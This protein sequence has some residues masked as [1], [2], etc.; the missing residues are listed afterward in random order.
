M[1]YDIF[2]FDP[3]AAPKDQ[4]SFSSWYATQTDWDMEKTYDDPQ[5]TTS[6]LRAWFMDMHKVFPAIGGPFARED[7]EGD[8]MWGDYSISDR[9]IYAAFPW[10]KAQEANSLAFELAQKHGI[11][12]YDCSDKCNVWLPKEDGNYGI[13][14]KNVDG[15]SPS[16]LSGLVSFFGKLFKL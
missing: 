10:P 16:P 4:A 5:T 11:G 2:V 14:L 8:D 3:A 1:S 12:L 9:I 13:A 6:S 7:D 15:R